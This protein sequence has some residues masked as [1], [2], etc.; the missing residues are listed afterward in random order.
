MVRK[1]EWMISKKESMHRSEEGG[2]AREGRSSP[3]GA[4]RGSCPGTAM[5][6]N[7]VNQELSASSEQK[8]AAAGRWPCACSRTSACRVQCRKMLAK[9]TSG[10]WT[11]RVRR[12]SRRSSCTLEIPSIRVFITAQRQRSLFASSCRSS[13]SRPPLP[14]LNHFSS[15]VRDT[16][17]SAPSPSP[18]ASPAVAA[19]AHFFHP[20][21]LV[22]APSGRLGLTEVQIQQAARLCFKA[23][24]LALDL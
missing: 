21:C 1:K 23:H 16:A 5:R 2:R 15:R 8:M 24:R 3:L 12:E 13:Y 9:R 19:C 7:Q 6:R 17:Q 18:S 11:G 4:E 20:S 14:R 22:T 10:A